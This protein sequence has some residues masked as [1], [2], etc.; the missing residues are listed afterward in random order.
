MVLE[1]GAHRLPCVLSAIPGHTTLKKDDAEIAEFF[2]VGELAGLI[3]G[4]D[5]RSHP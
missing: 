4:T 5:R 3:D 1:A 2:P